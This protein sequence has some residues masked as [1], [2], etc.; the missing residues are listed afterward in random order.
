MLDRSP[1]DLEGPSSG[2]GGAGA[3]DPTGCVTSDQC[4][5]SATLCQVP[6]CVAGECTYASKSAGSDCENDGVCDGEGFC[7]ASVGQT[8]DGDAAC[9]DAVCVDGVCCQTACDDL[10]SSCVIPGLEGTCSPEPSGTVSGD[11]PDSTCDGLGACVAG[12][13]VW[14]ATFGGSTSY[15][16]GWA[17]A[18][19]GMGN[20]YMLAEVDGTVDFGTTTVSTGISRDVALVKLGSDGT[21]LWTFQLVPTIDAYAY[22]VAATSDG[23][24]VAS[25]FFYGELDTKLTTLIADAS[26]DGWVVRFGP[27]AGALPPWATRVGG[28]GDER[29]FTVAA[30]ADGDDVLAGG[31]FTST[32]DFGPAMTVDSL[33]GYDGY[34]VRYGPT[35]NVVWY[36]TFG[37]T[38]DS[39]VAEVMFDGDEAIAVGGF[40][41]TVL[42]DENKN[43][44]SGSDIFAVRLDAAGTPTTSWT[45]DAAGN[46]EV[47]SAALMPDGGLVVVGNYDS[48]FQVGNDTLPF[49]GTTPFE[50]DVFVIRFD[51]GGTPIWARSFNGGSQVRAWD[52]AVDPAGN[53]LVGGSF[54][55]SADL[56]AGPE[57]SGNSGYSDAYLVKLS[58]N[59]AVHWVR[60][61]GQWWTDAVYGV[62]VDAAGHAFAAGVFEDQIMLD[63]TASAEGFVDAFAVH[64][65]P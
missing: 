17:I 38:E 65:G 37:G 33:G 20:T 39:A 2:S 45:L 24:A 31:V 21:P 13:L 1:G 23:G 3:D 28:D 30:A 26:A 40:V 64:L 16:E 56:G 54:E 12:D 51:D 14:G 4:E 42:L 25:G 8:C 9:H 41:G 36:R 29:V 19:D 48:E 5:P 60:T 59:G 58:P 63:S 22:D 43:A 47:T 46:Q 27:D 49:M 11:C 7:K 62:G 57:M 44:P 52:V 32:V 35:G 61:W 50:D 6:D 15:A 34:V 10:C 55:N 18:P 53:I